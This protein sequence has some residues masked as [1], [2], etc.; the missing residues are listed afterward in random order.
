MLQLEKAVF[1]L[2][3]LFMRLAAIQRS[4]VKADRKCV[5]TATDVEALSFLSLGFG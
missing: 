1:N 2:F 3:R 5:T 4:T